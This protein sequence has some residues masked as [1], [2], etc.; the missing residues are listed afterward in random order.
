[1]IIMNTHEKP[2]KS[3]KFWFHRRN[4]TIFQIFP[5]AVVHLEVS[6]RPWP[7]SLIFKDESWSHTKAR[8]RP[9][10]HRVV[11]AGKELDM[12]FSC[13][14]NFGDGVS[15]QII[16]THT[17]IYRERE[18]NRREKCISAFVYTYRYYFARVLTQ[19][20]TYDASEPFIYVCP[21]PRAKIQQHKIHRLYLCTET[22][23]IVLSF[24]F[25]TLLLF[26][27]VW[28]FAK[29]SMV[30]LPL[31]PHSRMNQTIGVSTQNLV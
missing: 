12:W 7:S 21:R 13:S 8:R 6:L 4:L 22:S 24:A 30:C 5:S 23:L 10:S 19:P 3:P 1:M 18:E 14:T 15:Q 31:T 27:V 20:N 28:I 16:D 26:T 2:I 17:H 25:S 11:S 29:S 9:E